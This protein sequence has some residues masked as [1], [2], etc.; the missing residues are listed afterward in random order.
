VT[1]S[2]RRP[3]PDLDHSSMSRSNAPAHGGRARAQR[4]RPSP[5]GPGPVPVFARAFHWFGAGTAT[6]SRDGRPGPA[7]PTESHRWPSAGAPGTRL[8]RGQGAGCARRSSASRS[9]P[10]RRRRRRRRG[11]GQPPAGALRQHRCR[12]R[13]VRSHLRDRLSG[14]V[15]RISADCGDRTSS[16]ERRPRSPRQPG[17][18]PG[19]PRTVPAAV[20]RSSPV[21]KYAHALPFAE[22]ARQLSTSRFHDLIRRASSATGRGL[23]NG[24]PENLMDRLRCRALS[25]GS[26]L[27]EGN[28]LRTELEPSGTIRFLA[29]GDGGVVRQVWIPAVVH[30]R[31]LFAVLVE[32]HHDV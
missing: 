29:A 17:P 15:R 7:V 32:D 18:E 21:P 31:E 2:S 22:P 23:A 11:G 14:R 12:P 1:P 3:C 5:P 26:T 28:S 9:P 10:D 13:R 30:I 8:G 24:Q 16:E 19:P 20:A 6:G 27:R 4:H 25:C